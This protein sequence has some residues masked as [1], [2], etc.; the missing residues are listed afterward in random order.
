MR[1]LPSLACLQRATDSIHRRWLIGIVP[2]GLVA[3]LFSP[4]VAYYLFDTHLS[5]QKEQLR[6]ISAKT[7]SNFDHE[8]TIRAYSVGAMRKTAEQYLMGRSQLSLDPTRYLRRSKNPQGYTLDLPAGYV[9]EEIGSITGAGPVPAANSLAAR[10]MAMTLGLLPLFQTVVARDK[11]T[12]WVY[13]TSQSRFT[14]LYPRV[15][16]QVFFYT[17]KSL[18][19]DVFTM[20]LPRN[21]PQR[22]VFWTPPYRDEAGKGMIVTVAAPVYEADHFRGSVAV[23]ITLSKLAWLLEHYELPHSKVYLYTEGGEYLAG[24]ANDRGFRPAEFTLNTVT[25]RDGNVITALPLK[26]VPWRILVVTSQSAMRNSALW[27]A[28]PFAL[29]VAFLFGS[30]MLIVALMSTLRKVQECSIRDGLTGIFNR[31]HFDASADRELSSAKRDGLYFG[32]IMLDIDHFKLYNDTYGHQSGDTVL[33]AISQILTNT[34]KRPMDHVYRVGGEEFAILTRAEQPEQI[35]T[36]AHLL[37]AAIVKGQLNFSAS[38]HGHIT[39]SVGVAILSPSTPMSLNVLYVKADQSLYR[40]KKEGR[41]RV[42]S[43]RA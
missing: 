37:H 30:A 2:L 20:A 35:E 22:N 31:R 9:E 5:Q 36:L 4:A 42:I 7:V 12:P 32:L 28:L 19:Y 34:L 3:L 40:A 21:N 1:Y 38:P 11:D 29:V 23:D 43:I 13:Y 27:Y 18:E 24:P 8:M 17:D 14:S 10:E 16:P 6:L 25:E 39:A 26:A 15:S 33:K 41:N